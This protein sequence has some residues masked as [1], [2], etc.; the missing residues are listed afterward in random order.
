MHNNSSRPCT[1]M[2]QTIQSINIL[3]ANEDN[4]SDSCTSNL[5]ADK[6]NRLINYERQLKFNENCKL[7]TVIKYEENKADLVHHWLDG[8]EL[9]YDDAR[10]DSNINPNEDTDLLTNTS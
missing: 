3:N 9:S 2:C 8:D 7:K 6:K 10:S 5:N 4:K 1:A